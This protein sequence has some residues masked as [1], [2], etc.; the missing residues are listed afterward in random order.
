MR[1]FFILLSILYF[2]AGST[3]ELPLGYIK[4]FEAG[5]TKSKMA[6]QFAFSDFTRAKITLTQMHIK[7]DSSPIGRLVPPGMA[8]VDDWIFGDFIS[9]V[10]LY[11]DCNPESSD[12]LKGIF[13]LTGLRDSSNYY[14]IHFNESAS[15]FYKM[16]KGKVSLIDADS[17]FVL[18]K[19]KWTSLRITRD[20]LGRTLQIEQNGKSLSFTDPNLIMGYIG[21]GVLESSLNIRK[22]VIWA[23][24][25]I[26]KEL[27]VFSSDVQK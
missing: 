5:Y 3:Q 8:L 26:N 14:F 24:T 18:P 23:P 2:Y 21:F 10:S 22:F 11:Y 16:Y 9:E 15:N 19:E 17:S 20:I 25:A 27:F 7:N 1:Y 4:Y 6:D 13:L 12:S